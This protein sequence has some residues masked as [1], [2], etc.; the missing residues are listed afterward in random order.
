MT[1]EAMPK[2]DLTPAPETHD[3]PIN[4][5]QASTP[6]GVFEPFI[7]PKSPLVTLQGRIYVTQRG[8]YLYSNVLSFSSLVYHP[9]AQVRSFPY[10]YRY[11]YQS[12]TP[13]SWISTLPPNHKSE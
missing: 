12:Y 13:K 10:L 4:S 5:A 3:T 1:Q 8:M 2:P 9:L 7:T 6:N 11:R